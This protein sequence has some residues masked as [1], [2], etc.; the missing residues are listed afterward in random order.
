MI[1]TL[2]NLTKR[3]SVKS[4][5]ALDPRVLFEAFEKALMKSAVL[6]G[7]GSNELQYV[8]SYNHGYGVGPLC[9]FRCRDERL[10]QAFDLAI[11]TG[12]VP[13]RKL[14]YVW[15]LDARFDSGFLMWRLSC[16]DS[17]LNSLRLEEF[18]FSEVQLRR[19]ITF[20]AER[21]LWVSQKHK[22]VYDKQN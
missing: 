20:I 14:H 3:S 11:S 5:L 13:P 12:Y 2:L 7:S 22:R 9:H 15:T 10:A 16:V 18:E 17:R 21:F 4:F 8:S 1:A 6:L 19:D